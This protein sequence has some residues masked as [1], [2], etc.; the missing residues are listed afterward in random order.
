MAKLDKGLK[1]ILDKYEIDY[2]D[3]SKLWDC[4]GTLVLYHKA[5]EIIAVTE[6]ITFD[7]PQIVE[8]NSKDRIVSICVTGHMGDRSEWSFGEAAPG[9]CTNKYP[10]AMA[11]KRAKDRV[12]A[13]LVGL[14]QFVYS[15]D[16]AEE[17]KEK[18]GIFI[19]LGADDVPAETW[20]EGKISNLEEFVCKPKS[21]LEKLELGDS[22][23][24]QDPIFKK[25]NDEQI[26]QYEEAIKEARMKLTARMEPINA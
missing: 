9:N 14:A 21:T 1:A 22:K 6:K 23:T 8:S 10:Y 2:Q 7:A 12:I 25:L 18:K 19:P 5:Y 26:L 4:H 13:K 24:R 11:E 17:F 3:K 15:E 16:E 20:L